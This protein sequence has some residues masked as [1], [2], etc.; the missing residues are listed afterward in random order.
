MV[1]ICLN[2][3][4]KIYWDSASACQWDIAFPKVPKDGS[5]LVHPAMQHNFVNYDSTLTFKLKQ[6]YKN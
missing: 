3:L 1:S 6:E 5:W 2:I 4:C